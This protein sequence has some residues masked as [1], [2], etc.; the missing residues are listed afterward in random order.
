MLSLTVRF[1]AGRYDSWLSVGIT[2]GNLN[3]EISAISIDFSRWN[4]LT[5]LSVIDGAVFWMDPDA[6]SSVEQ[7]ATVVAQLT[8]PTGQGFT[9]VINAQGKNLVNSQAT[10]RS[11]RKNNIVFSAPDAQAASKENTPE[12]H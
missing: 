4:E 9:A 11:W 7:G 2:D 10:S 12:N 5:D 1:C 3:G 6:A 8:L